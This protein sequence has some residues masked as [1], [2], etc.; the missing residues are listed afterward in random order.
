MFD[1]ITIQ[2]ILALYEQASGQQLNKEKTTI[3]F[4]KAVNEDTKSEIT[5][6]LGVPEVKE[7][8]KYLGLST[9]VGRNKKASLI[10]IK[11]RIWSK[12]QGWKEKL[13]FQAGREILLKAVVQAIRTFTMSCFKLPVELCNEVESLIR[14]FFWGENESYAWQSI[15]KARKVTAAGMLWR[16]G[17]GE[18][19]QLYDDNWLPGGTSSRILSPRVDELKNSMVACLMDS[20]SGGWN[21]FLVDQYFFPFEAQRIKEILLYATR[22]EDCLTLSRTK[23][24]D[25]SVKSGYQLSDV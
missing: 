18:C 8:E 5:S 6:F 24:C 4:S 12:L 1:L 11:E 22:Q 13:L 10:Y 25:Y 16:V 14:K 7:Y 20:A 3:F 23:G 15:L 9:V 19:I 17:N 2:N 21:N